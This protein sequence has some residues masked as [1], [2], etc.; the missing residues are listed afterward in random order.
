MRTSARSAAGR[1]PRWRPPDCSRN[2]STCSASGHCAARAECLN[3][4]VLVHG[5]FVPPRDA[6]EELTSAVLSV[7]REVV[8]EA[9]QKRGFLRRRPDAP[10]P[11]V[12]PV[13]VD[14]PVD[15]MKLP[16][17]GFGNLAA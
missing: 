6:L 12:P 3:G 15:A 9:E 2:V 11:D 8:V 5:V 1:R 16:I 7:R 10:V 13:L 4:R 17:T 14:V